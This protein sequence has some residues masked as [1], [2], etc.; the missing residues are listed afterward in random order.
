MFDYRGSESI[1]YIPP[2]NPLTKSTIFGFNFFITY[3]DQNA[4]CYVTFYENTK[5]VN[6]SEKHENPE[7][8]GI[9]ELRTSQPKID[10]SQS[11]A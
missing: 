2:K 1:F 9:I 6:V 11:Q 8:L 10:S 5:Y 7:C 3:M 4:D